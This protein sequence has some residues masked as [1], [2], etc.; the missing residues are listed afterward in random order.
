LLLAGLGPVNAQ[1]TLYSSPTG[2]TI[3]RSAPWWDYDGQQILGAINQTVYLWDA[4]TGHIVRSFGGHVEHVDLAKFS[5]DGKYV[6]TVS[7]NRPADFEIPHPD[8][9]T[10]LWDRNTG[11]LIWRLEGEIY[12]KLSADGTRLLTIS[13]KSS[14]A[15][16]WEVPSGRKLVRVKGDTSEMAISQDDAFFV[17]GDNLYRAQ[18]GI[19]IATPKLLFNYNMYGPQ[20]DLVMANLNGTFEIWNH[21]DGSKQ[22]ILAAEGGP[23]GYGPAWTP[24]GVYVVSNIDTNRD[25]KAVCVTR[26]WTVATGK[27]IAPSPCPALATSLMM[28]PH[29][30]QFLA[31]WGELDAQ[32]RTTHEAPVWGLFNIKDGHQLWQTSDITSPDDVLGFATD[33]NTLL[34]FA[35]N[36]RINSPDRT[37]VTII[38]ADTG[39]PIRT[40]QLQQP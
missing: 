14:S 29:H 35:H 20:G 23:R 28:R 40:L 10:R 22:T 32:L 16:L 21:L 13:L 11:K 15:T 5:P 17:A 38:R 30:D 8:S 27:S 25:R 19:R 24:D 37:Q 36:T 1:D 7:Y 4:S 39:K 2:S 26:I 33:G 9:A 34:A 6:L 18:D 31:C 3:S 12:A